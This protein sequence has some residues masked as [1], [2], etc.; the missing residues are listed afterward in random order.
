MNNNDI[1]FVRNEV[2]MNLVNFWVGQHIDHSIGQQLPWLW[3]ERFD[4]ICDK[5]D[6]RDGDAAGEAGVQFH[7]L[8]VA[9]FFP[10]HIK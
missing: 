6:L 9:L 3:Q 7:L 10:D 8:V 2:I 1:I 4:E 5:Y